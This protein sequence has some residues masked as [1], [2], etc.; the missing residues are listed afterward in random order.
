MKLLQLK[1]KKVLQPTHILINWNDK[2]NENT[3]DENTFSVN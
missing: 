1:Q 2:K 3:N